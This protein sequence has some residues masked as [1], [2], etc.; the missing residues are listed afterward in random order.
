MH[1]LVTQDLSG[2]EAGGTQGK[3]SALRVPVMSTVRACVRTVWLPTMMLLL[4]GQAGVCMSLLLLMPATYAHAA[5]ALGGV[6]CTSL[7][8]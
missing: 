5:H 4:C 6:Q 2:P 7:H 3:G 8:E 1:T